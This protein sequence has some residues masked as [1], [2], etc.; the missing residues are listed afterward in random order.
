[1][2]SWILGSLVVLGVS[3]VLLM[4]WQQLRRLR[5]RIDREGS[6]LPPVSVLKPLKGVD[7]DLERNLETF[8]ALDYPEYELVFGVQEASDPALPVARRVADRHPLITSRF[9]IGGAEVGLNPKVNNLAG[10]LQHCRH[11]HLWISDSNVAVEPTVL[12]GMMHRLTDD[13]GLVTSFIRGVGGRGVGGALEA[14]Q[15]NT[16]VMGSVAAVDSSTDRVCAVGKS[17]L[18]R[19]AELEAVGGFSEL[20]RYL[21]EDQILGEAIRGL[22]TKVVVSSQPIDNVL[23]EMSVA[24]FAGRFLRW[25][26]IRRRISRGGYLAELLVNPLPAAACLVALEPSWTTAMVALG[27]VALVAACGFVVE[28]RLDIR[29]PL[30][31]YPLLTVIRSM[32]VA[33]LWLVPFFSSTVEWRGRT[34]RIGHRTLLCS[35][36]SRAAAEIDELAPE[37][38]AA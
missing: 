25:A 20:G 38:A 9:A 23:G 26:R 12:R 13:V 6:S 36:R 3:L 22:G 24:Q 14:L 18:F 19:R 4:T 32:V 33:V 7:A 34:Y 28:R 1:M 5:Q 15:L 16:F 37:E 11:D 21:G 31:A 10:I 8:Y 29:R 2:A 35:D 27:V 30:L 17:M